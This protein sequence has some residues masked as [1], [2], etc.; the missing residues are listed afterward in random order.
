MGDFQSMKKRCPIGPP[1]M[2]GDEGTYSGGDQLSVGV[3]AYRPVDILHHNV[4]EVA[5]MNAR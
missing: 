1:P 5:R 3:I 2:D 4:A